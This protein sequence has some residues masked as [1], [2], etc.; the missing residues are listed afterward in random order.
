MRTRPFNVVLLFACAVF[1][2]SGGI[3][4]ST[5][6]TNPP[7]IGSFTANPTA[8]SA[9]QSSVLSWSVS[10]A[11]SINIDN[12][13]G[14]VGSS[15]TMSITPAASVI[16]MLTATNTAGTVTAS[17]ALAVTG[18]AADATISI[19]TSQDRRTVS[20]FVYGYN[21]GSAAGSDLVALGWKSVDR[22]QLDQQLLE[23]RERLRPVPQR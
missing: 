10:G 12:G 18:A 23:R 17:V 9:G 2:C 19:D 6:Q 1:G 7:T 5:Q 22:L 11:S 14:N 16:Y 4:G 13:V 3:R 21:A 15:G 20:P 8:I